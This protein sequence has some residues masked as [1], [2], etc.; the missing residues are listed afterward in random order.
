M[1]LPEAK[2]QLT[3]VFVGCYEQ[4]SPLMGK[5][6]HRPI[7]QPRSCFC[8]VQNV[9]PKPSQRL[10]DGFVYA[11]VGNEPHAARSVSGLG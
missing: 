1:Q 2:D 4:R 3:K 11:L 7:S 9:V 5:L 6:Q 10:D 8:D